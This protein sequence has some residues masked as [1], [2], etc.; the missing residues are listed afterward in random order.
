M[1]SRMWE[2]PAVQRNVTQLERMV[3]I[4]CNQARAGLVADKKAPVAWLNQTR[5]SMRLEIIYRD[6]HL[7]KLQDS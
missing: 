6:V 7:T 4:S 5:S 3:S 2:Q 1:N